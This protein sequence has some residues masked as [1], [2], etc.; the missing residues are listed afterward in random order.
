M[1]F[2]CTAIGFNPTMTSATFAIQGNIIMTKEEFKDIRTRWKLTV[3]Q[4]GELLGGYETSTIYAWENGQNPIPKAV[5]VC[6]G[7]IMT[8]Q[9]EAE[10]R[11]QASGG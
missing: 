10:E 4:M 7:L 11:Q 6:I 8:V 2:Q 9:Q 3:Q 5:V 1:P